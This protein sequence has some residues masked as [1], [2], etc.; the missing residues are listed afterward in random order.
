MELS[1]TWTWVC[2]CASPDG[3]RPRM[4]VYMDHASLVAFN[5]K[6]PQTR[7]LEAVPFMAV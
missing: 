2:A 6:G 3:A 4:I 7:I 1:V 5:A